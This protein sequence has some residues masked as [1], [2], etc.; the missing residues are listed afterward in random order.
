MKVLIIAAGEGSRLKDLTKD[1]PKPLV[2]LLGLSLIERVILTAKQA[3]IKEFV[4]TI[5]YLG[6]KIKARLGNGRKYGVSIEYVENKEWEKGNGLSVLKAKDVIKE[7]FILLMSDHIFDPTILIDLI[8]IKIE[9]GECIL[10]IDRNINKVFDLEDATK[11]KT[12]NNKIMTI[13]KN[14]SR[15]NAIDTG[16]FLCTNI[17]F[18]VINQSASKG[19]STISGA[20]NI[21]ASKGKMRYFDIKKRFWI[22][23]DNCKSLK[24]A[25]KII[26]KSLVK[27]NDGPISKILNRKISLRISSYLVKTNINPNFITVITFLVSLLSAFFFS[28]GH[29]YYTLIGGLL[30][31]FSS[32]IDG[33]DGEIAR[34]KFK[35][36][37]YG[38]WFDS[39]LDRYA[40]AFI[41]FGMTYGYFALNSNYFIWPLSFIALTGSFINSYTADK[42]T[43]LYKQVYVNKGFSLKISRD[44]RLFLIM[45]AG[46]FNIIVP[47]L[48]LLAILTNIEN[49]RRVIYLKENELKN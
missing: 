20:I 9:E 38:A 40:D 34:L 29:Y 48:I 43:C 42:Y 5:G 26:S 2:Q 41:L 16:V 33:C 19:D 23:I 47:I 46:I 17:I 39:V 7:N 1:K 28:I 15:Y 37:N 13:G 4:I 32:I 44:V 36:S 3:G 27:K 24:Q 8:N 25:K 6:D 10:C 12:V 22:D 11:V 30:A 35:Q 21:L 31:Q 18:E 45:I 49:V 14:L